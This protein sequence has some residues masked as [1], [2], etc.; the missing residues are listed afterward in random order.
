MQ[1]K[2]LL[3]Q[4]M[5]SLATPS[6]SATTTAL[7]TPQAAVSQAQQ[8][9]MQSVFNALTTQLNSS[10]PQPQQFNPAPVNG[11]LTITP[12]ALAAVKQQ[13]E[14]VVLRATGDAQPPVTPKAQSAVISRIVEQLMRSDARISV[15]L[16]QQGQMTASPSS[17][18][19]N[20][21]AVPLTQLPQPIRQA[22]SEQLQQVL[23]QWVKVAQAKSTATP[24]ALTPLPIQINAIKVSQGQLTMQLQTPSKVVSEVSVPLQQIP[25]PIARALLQQMTTSVPSQTQQTAATAPTSTVPTT[26][27]PTAPTVDGRLVKQTQTLT[28]AQLTQFLRQVTEITPQQQPEVKQLLTQTLAQLPKG[29]Q[30]MHPQQL[31]N[32]VSDWFAAKPVSS[33]P[34]QQLGVVGKLII[35]LLGIRMQAQQSTQPQAAKA[36]SQAILDQ[37]M[38]GPGEARAGDD[39]VL[40]PRP[41]MTAEVRERL[42]AQLL[43]QPAAQLQRLLSNL[44]QTMNSAQS[45]QMRLQDSPAQQPEFYLMLPSQ[46]PSSQTGTEL[47]IKRESSG[48]SDDKNERSVWLFN[49]RFELKQWGPMLV[50]GRYQTAGT[51]V[52]FFTE[53]EAAQRHLQRQLPEL[54]Q[55]LAGL[56]VAAVDFQIKQGKVPDSLAQQHSGI[57]R[58]TV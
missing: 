20:K 1:I 28:P 46:N 23:T 33:Q 18:V 27:A 22:V 42:N 17:N 4:M 10:T 6:N 54:E 12:Q 25:Q 39:R 8:N 34:N 7:N 49:L 32:Y 30:M 26:P 37:I 56:D 47:L 15:P 40:M 53:S 3:Q 19:S 2:Q 41:P 21:I 14:Q 36:L 45:S 11:Q 52:Q 24:S 35:A 43:Q 31:A 48:H 55:R 16:R 57:I 13:L 51:R 5:Q 50:K 58:V 38:R 9:A 44:A 29:E